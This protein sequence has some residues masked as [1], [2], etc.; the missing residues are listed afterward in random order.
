MPG[1]FT[2]KSVYWHRWI[3]RNYNSC[4]LFDSVNACLPI[5]DGKKMV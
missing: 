5:K 3:Q 4:L 1:F 2:I